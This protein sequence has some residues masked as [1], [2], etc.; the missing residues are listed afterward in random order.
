MDWKSLLAP[1]RTTG[2]GDPFVALRREM[3]RMI[4]QF[5]RGFAMPGLATTSTGFVSPRVNVAETEKGLEISAELPGFKPEE[6]SLD[7]EGDVLTLKAERRQEREEKEEEKRYHLIERMSGSYLRRFALPFAPQSDAVQARFDN[8]VLHV[9][10]PRPPDAPKGAS[11]I[12]I[13][14]GG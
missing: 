7:L 14:A 1:G 12:A 11:R 10:L 3:D 9:F 8:G 2:E 13:Q 5:G 4:E 6:V